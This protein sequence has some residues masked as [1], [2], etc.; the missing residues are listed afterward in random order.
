MN[1][2]N[3]LRKYR[4]AKG[5]TINRLSILSGVDRK[6][7]NQFERETGSIREAPY[8]M[9]E[10]LASTLGCRVSDLIQR[11]Y[12]TVEKKEK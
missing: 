4:E 11:G 8:Y 3:K 9:I 2:E 12:K 1:G 6:R 7:I 5:I 10:A